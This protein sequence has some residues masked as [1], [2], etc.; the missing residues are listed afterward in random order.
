MKIKIAIF[1]VILSLLNISC[2]PEKEKISDANGE[3]YS[4]IMKAFTSCQAHFI[5]YPDE[6][7][8]IQNRISD[9]EDIQDMLS[10]KMKQGSNISE[11]GKQLKQRKRGFLKSEKNI[12][13][14]ISGNQADLRIITSHINGNK[15]YVA[16]SKGMIAPISKIDLAIATLST[17]QNQTL[18]SKQKKNI[19]KNELIQE[20]YVK[21]GL[22]KQIPAIISQ[23]KNISSDMLFS[24][25]PNIK[26]KFQKKMNKLFVTDVLENRIKYNLGR[27][28]ENQTI[29]E[30]LKWL[31]STLGKKITEL[32]E[33]ASSE[34][35]EEEM[36]AYIESNQ[37]DSIPEK[38]FNLIKKL[39]NISNSIDTA[40]DLGIYISLSIKTVL[41]DINSIIPTISE[42]HI[43]QHIN[44]NRKELIK[45]Y[46]HTQ[47]SLIKPSLKKQIYS[48]LLYIYRSLSD[49]ELTKYIEFAES[50]TGR[51]YLN[52]ARNFEK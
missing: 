38:R 4:T 11:F 14:S 2:K 52:V 49:E 21:S 41:N 35:G 43:N 18:Q 25:S 34:K 3:A 1:F 15:A 33:Q 12:N 19:V 26:D 5:N 29:S 20:I 48:S 8:D 31:N 39:A 36:T 37:T 9:D 44:N 28:L 40:T 10:D 27:N 51:I 42:K 23:V 16:D 7:I 22:T 47:R 17:D 46:I 45:Q 32:E 13:I 30:V 6:K 24:L 50:K